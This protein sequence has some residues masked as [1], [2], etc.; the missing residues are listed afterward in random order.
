MKDWKAIAKAGVPE[1]PAGEI[2]RVVGPLD[3]LEE[4]FRPL[5]KD[6]PMDLEPALALGVE[7]EGQ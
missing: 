7:E 2:D 6:L 5:V 1:I 4:T 3:A